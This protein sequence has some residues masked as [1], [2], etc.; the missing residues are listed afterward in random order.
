MFLHIG[1]K[2][3]HKIEKLILDLFYVMNCIYTNV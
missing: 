3:K 2:I 1:K